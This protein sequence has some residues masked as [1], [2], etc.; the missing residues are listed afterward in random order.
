[1]LGKCKSTPQRRRRAPFAFYVAGLLLPT[2]TILL[3]LALSTRLVQ[4]AYACIRIDHRIYRG[5]PPE[6]YDLLETTLFDLSSG[7]RI[8][9]PN[10]DQVGANVYSGTVQRSPDGNYIAF[11]Q[12]ANVTTQFIDTRCDNYR[13]EPKHWFC[14]RQSPNT[15]FRVGH[16][17]AVGIAYFVQTGDEFRVGISELLPPYRTLTSTSTFRGLHF[18]GWSPDGQYLA[19][20]GDVYEA[21]RTIYILARTDLHIVMSGTRPASTD[22]SY[23]DNVNDSAWSP[24]GNLF[25]YYSPNQSNN[26]L[27]LLSPRSAK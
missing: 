13:H 23:Y 16:Q 18:L 4:T 1:M 2:T 17:I 21:D 7:S 9:S 25:A 8:D 12:F 19:L 14:G 24:H 20:G 11:E 10:L 5:G 22:S 26:Q 27:I 3:V 15:R 6:R